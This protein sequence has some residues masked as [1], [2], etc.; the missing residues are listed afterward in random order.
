MSTLGSQPQH[1]KAQD[2]GL[3]PP[4]ANRGALPPSLPGLTA[5]QLPLLIP[6][7]GTHTHSWTFCAAGGVFPELIESIFSLSQTCF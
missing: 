3:P 2:K 4:L 7:Q 1:P 5:L 6:S